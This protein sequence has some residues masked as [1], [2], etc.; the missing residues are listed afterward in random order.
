MH[1]DVRIEY[2]F[3][4]NFG[5]KVKVMQIVSIDPNKYD[6]HFYINSS[7]CGEIWQIS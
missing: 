2:I 1:I 5:K 7:M 6:I 4:V 3:Q